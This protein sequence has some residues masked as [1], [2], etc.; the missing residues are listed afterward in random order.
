MIRA[1]CSWGA[2][3]DVLIINEG[4]YYILKEPPALTDTFTHDG[5]GYRG[6][7][8]NG[9]SFEGLISLSVDEEI[10]TNREEKV[11]IL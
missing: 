2:G 1:I 8:K 5:K 11:R 7:Y 4:A 9:I 3:E 10:S 6:Y